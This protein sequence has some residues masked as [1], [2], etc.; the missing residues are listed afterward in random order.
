MMGKVVRAL[1]L[2]NRYLRALR[3]SSL[4]DPEHNSITIGTEVPELEMEKERGKIL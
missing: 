4:R 2:Q 1:T 3:N